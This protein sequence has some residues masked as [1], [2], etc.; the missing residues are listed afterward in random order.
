ME[1]HLGVHCL[2]MYPAKT[3]PKAHG[4]DK[5][6]N[7]LMHLYHI[8]IRYVRMSDFGVYSFDRISLSESNIHV[9]DES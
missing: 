4:T 7:S 9:K 1:R 2:R 5:V 3:N 8:G 6:T